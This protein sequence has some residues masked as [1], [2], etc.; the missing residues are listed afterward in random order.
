MKYNVKQAVSGIQ[1]NLD[2][3]NQNALVNRG[4]GNLFKGIAGRAETQ[5]KQG[6]FN[7]LDKALQNQISHYEKMLSGPDADP[8]KKQMIEEKINQFKF[9]NQ[10]LNMGNMDKFPDLY[11]T[12]IGDER[13]LQNSLDIANI[14]ANARIKA[15]E[16][17]S[18]GNLVKQQNEANTLNMINDMRKNKQY[19][20]TA[21]S[22]N[23]KFLEETMGYLFDPYA[24]ENYSR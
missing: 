1:G 19:T 2:Q 21:I 7:Q 17:M 23:M 16:N 5:I 20:P 3:A 24:I 11:G 4:L 12:F 6:E 10:T 14:G 13:K 15:S 18:L 8:A 22:P 9:L